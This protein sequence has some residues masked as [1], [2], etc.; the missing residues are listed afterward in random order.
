MRSKKSSFWN[1]VLAWIPGCSEMYMGFMKMGLSLMIAFWGIVALSVVLNLGPIMFIG[2]IAWFY[3]FFHARNLYHMEYSEFIALEDRYLYDVD[4]LT[5]SGEKVTQKYRN[6]IAVILIVLGI[7]LVFRGIFDAFRGILPQ[8]VLDIYWN[9]SYYLPQI[10]VGVGIILLGKFLIDGKK[11][12]LYEDSKSVEEGAVNHGNNTA[13]T[14]E[15]TVTAESASTAE[16]T[17]TAESAS[18]AEPADT[19][20]SADTDGDK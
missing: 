13:S 11:R 17:D 8:V 6:V 5:V 15:P 2:M 16:P 1:F 20:E 19:V 14:A 12:E 3:S 10:V 18:T 9:A 7:V 4:R